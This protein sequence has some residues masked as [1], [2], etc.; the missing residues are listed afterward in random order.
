[1]VCCGRNENERGL[2]VNKE[3][4][5]MTMKTIKKTFGIAA[6]IGILAASATSVFAQVNFNSGTNTLANLA[7][8]GTLSIDDKIFSGFNYQASGLTFFDPNQIIVTATENGGIDYL[9]WS[10]NISLVSSGIASADLLLNY[11]VTA[12]PGAI[13]M[14]DQSYTG[15]AQNGLL[16]V[17]ETA[18]TGAFGGIVVGYSH[19][20][21]GYSSDPPAGTVSGD[22]LNIN[23]SQSVL[24]VTKDIALAVISPN[25]GSISIVQ[26]EQS[27]HQVPEPSAM[28]LGSLGGGLLLFLRLRR[29]ARRETAA[30]RHFSKIAINGMHNDQHS[31]LK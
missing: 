26:V 29:Q 23:P 19:L 7:N 10:G 21:V 24:Y 17:D 20:Q 14:I 1:V 2:T 3:Q 8:G 22:N 27:F 31:D 18:A 11:I 15:R 16:A 6:C 30:I 4:K 12:N 9:T 25:G 5:E 13:N 28:L